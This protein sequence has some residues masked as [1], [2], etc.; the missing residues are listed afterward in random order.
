MK[1]EF[2]IGK[3]YP[4]LAR[5]SGV[6]AQFFVL[7]R[8]FTL[9]G[10][11]IGGFFLDMFFAVMEFGYFNFLHAFVVG[12]AMM[13]FQAGGQA[14]NQ[15]VP[16]E[17]AID[18]ANGK[19]YRP[20]VNGSMSIRTAT[21][22]SAFMFII[23]IVLSFLLNPLMGIFSFVMVFFAVAYTQQPFRVKRLFV[24]N[25]IWQGIAR[26]FLPAVYVSL[27]YPQWLNLALAFGLFFMAWVTTAQTTKDFPDWE[28][29]MKFGIRTLP[30]VLGWKPSI[31]VM[32]FGFGYTFMLLNWL[33]MNSLLPMFFIWL[34]IMTIP[35]A[36]IIVSLWFGMK[37]QYAENNFAW[38]GFYASLGITYMLPALIVM[39]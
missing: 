12:I 7:I 31:L 36:L 2:G 9:F 24:M 1:I 8:P 39:W 14:Y 37:F 16:E 19:I 6:V 4:N 26:G 21:M 38:V 10:A 33:I 3:G 25:N 15:C 28:G 17:I 11:W 20:T 13:M 18:R 35:S 23:S 29:D 22:I 32:V 34:N 5:L 27:L 30:V